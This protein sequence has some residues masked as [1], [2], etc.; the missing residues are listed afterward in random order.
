VIDILSRL[1]RMLACGLALR[2]LV[3]CLLAGLAACSDPQPPMTVQTLQQPS[4]VTQSLRMAEYRVA[5]GDRI[6][7]VVLSDSELSGE[8][9]I[10]SAGMISPRMAGR[11]QVVGMTTTE[12]EEILRNRYRADG[13]LRVPRLS[14]DLVARRPFYILGEVARPGSFPYVSGINVAQ[15]IAIAGGFSR[16][17]AKTRITIQRFNQTWGMEETV[18]EDSPVGPGDIIRVPERW[19]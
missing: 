7:V 1:R 15:A 18:T 8:Y 9:E 14:V 12:I 10:D 4:Q 2:A 6:R 17:A 3:L 19:F 13:L 16:R 5:P 11:V